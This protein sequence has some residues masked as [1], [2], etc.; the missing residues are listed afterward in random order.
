MRLNVSRPGRAKLRDPERPSRTQYAGAI[1]PHKSFHSHARKLVAPCISR[2][3]HSGAMSNPIRPGRRVELEE[4]S[5]QNTPRHAVIL[6]HAREIARAIASPANDGGEDVNGEP[7][8]LRE[9]DGFKLD[10][11]FHQVRNEC[12]AEHEAEAIST[13]TKAA[14]AAAKARGVKLGGFRGRAGSPASCAL[15]R[16]ARPIKRGRLL[17]SRTF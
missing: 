12:N 16:R 7:I 11:R 6:Y 2:R 5:A 13:R 4:T 17:M 8:G 10:A 1:A 14:L 3:S 15:A 9:I